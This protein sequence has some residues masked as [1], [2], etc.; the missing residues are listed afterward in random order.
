MTSSAIDGHAI[1]NQESPLTHSCAGAHELPS[2]TR[3]EGVL[4]DDLARKSRTPMMRLL[5]ELK[6]RQMFRVAAAYAVVG[7]LILQVVNNLAPGLNLPNW[8]ITL[9][10][11]LLGAGFP[12]ALLFCWIQQL[13][14]ADSAQAQVKVNRL[15]WILAGGLAAVIALLLY[16]QLAPTG[17]TTAQGKGDAGAT[18]EA[19]AGPGIAIAV[20]PFANLS[21]DAAQEFFSDGTSEEITSALAK[22]QGLRVVGRSSAFQFKGQSR[23]LRAIGQ[24]L[25]A[26]YLID[27]SVR[28]AG[29]RVR[30]T[31]QLIQ[32]DDGIGLWTE[33]Y[34]RELTDIFAI[35]EDIAQAIA[36]ALRVPL[37]LGRGELLVSSRSIDP[38]SY[39][40][41]LRAKALVLARGSGPAE[42]VTILEPLVARHP[43]YAPAWM[44]LAWA[45][46]FETLP[47]RSALTA[48]D[49]KAAMDRG[50]ARGEEAARRALTL[51]ANLAEGYMFLGIVQGARNLAQA[52]D[53]FS[54]ALALDPNNSE[55]LHQYSI[56]LAFEGRLKE[57]LARRQQLRELDPFV[58][59][60]NRATANVLWLTGQDEAAIALYNRDPTGGNTELQ[61]ARIW[62]A[63][64]RY[65]E[66]ADSV[67]RMNAAAY[68]TG[69]I[70]EAIRLLRTAPAAAPPQSL[71][72]LG[73][74]GFVYLHVGAPERALDF[75]EDGFF[76]P[77]DFSLLWH[78]SYA[79]VRKTDRFKALMRKVG[80]VDYWRAKGW[81]D[82]CRPV[83]ADDFVCD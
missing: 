79:P 17:T 18:A 40:Q 62:A 80:L 46:G 14:P 78:P 67:Q 35:Q 58:P 54:K 19:N 15:D 21:G 8:A 69:V 63:M 26:R 72:R 13:S 60:Y 83:G 2:P 52:E 51:D 36:A 30:I 44:Q 74:L 43:D 41:Y 42:A 56:F 20:L 25:S 55:A 29:N 12:L 37:G 38:A 61:L 1:Q 3:G 68:P 6:R 45:Y 53:L 7:W 66:A 5:A 50:M 11:V 23:D 71:P 76:I 22:V 39:Q 73:I 59:V 57:A 24:A 82:L 10:I 4:A 65:A 31:A 33:N 27:G 49:A 9:V 32:A 16:Q 64:G 48:A 77:P 34:D 47:G 28:M 81:P 70:A 75:Y